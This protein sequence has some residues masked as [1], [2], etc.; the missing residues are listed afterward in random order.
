MYYMLKILPNGGHKQKA[1]TYCMRRLPNIIDDK[2]EHSFFFFAAHKQTN[3][4]K[5]K[6]NVSSAFFL[7]EVRNYYFRK[8]L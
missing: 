5:N 1:G 3:F 8:C 7:E 4:Y 6:I 2:N